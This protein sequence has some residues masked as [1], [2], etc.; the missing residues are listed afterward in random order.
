MKKSFD[1]FIQ[2]ILVLF[3]VGCGSKGSDNSGQ[4]DKD[5]Q[6]LYNEIMDIHDEVMP[7]T[8]QLYNISKQ[9]KGNLKEAT[10]DAERELLQNQIDYFDSVNMMMMDW[11]H[12][13]KTLPDTTSE[14]TARQYY[15]SHL[16]KIKLVREA[17]LTALDK[18]GN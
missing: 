10:M 16:Q 3:L 9:L 2:I 15:E 1:Q 13:F 11:M 5:N 18:G 14:Q 7:K 6:V 12:E 17:I 8:E 4:V